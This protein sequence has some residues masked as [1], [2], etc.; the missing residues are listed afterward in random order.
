[1]IIRLKN[2]KKLIG[3][4]SYSHSYPHCRRCETPLISRALTSRFIKEPELT[5]ITVPNAEKISFVPDSVKNRFIDV[6][7]SAPDWNLSRNR[8]WGAPLP[9]WENQDNLEEKIVIGTLDELYHHTKTGSK[10]ITKHVLI[11]HGQTIYNESNIHDS[12]SVTPLN[13][14]GQQQS[15]EVSSHIEKLSSTDDIIL[16]LTPLLRTFQTATPYLQKKYGKEFS[17]IQQAYH[18]IE[19]IYQDLRNKSTIQDYL[20]DPST[21]KLFPINDYLFVDFRTVDL[22]VPEY[23]DAEFPK[24]LTTQIPTKQKLTPKGESIDDVEMRCRD[25][26]FDITTKQKGK[27]IVTITHKDSVI[28]LQKTFK[29][30]DYISKKHEYSPNN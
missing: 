18:D 3:Q 26:L 22:I 30:F 25:Y 7:K 6:L 24:N 12:Y 15:Q 1:M 17:V 19:R 20:K 21:Q 10:N 28:L 27:T 4:K 14:K 16:V 13:E 9:I 2:E 11:R 8:Y 29:D 23:Q 5:S